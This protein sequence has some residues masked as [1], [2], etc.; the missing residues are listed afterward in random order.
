ME[1]TYRVRVYN[2][3]YCIEEEDV[4]SEIDEDASIE[5]D[6]EEYYEAIHNQIK[7]LKETLPQDLILTITCEKEDLEE[8]V[9]DD[10]TDLTGWLLNGFKFEIL[11]RRKAR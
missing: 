2:I 1:K 9:C 6:S 3:D 4:C 8:L 11:E 7:Y 5:E 10:V